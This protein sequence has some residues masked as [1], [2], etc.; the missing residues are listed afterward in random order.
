ME[1]F[2]V[3]GFLNVIFYLGILGFAIYFVAAMLHRSRERNEYLKEILAELR[4]QNADEG[5]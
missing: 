3:F 2:M 1:S 4:K 5:R